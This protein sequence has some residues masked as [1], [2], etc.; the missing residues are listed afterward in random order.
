[1][2]GS[3]LRPAGPGNCWVAAVACQRDR[4]ADQLRLKSYFPVARKRDI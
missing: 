4:I 1:M 3:A 2:I